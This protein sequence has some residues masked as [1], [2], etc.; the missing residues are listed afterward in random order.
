MKRLDYLKGYSAYLAKILRELDYSGV[1]KVVECLLQGRL[2]GST[3]FFIGN[4]GSAATASHF[5]QD[6]GETG[7][8][9][10]ARSFRSISLC[11]SM[12][13]VTALS[14]DYG[15]DSAF[16]SQLSSLF[17]KQDIL[18]A[19]SASG[20]S[21]NIVKAV[22][23][24]N[25]LKGITIGLVGFDGGKLLRMC[26]YALHV[27]TEEGEYGPVEDAH[28]ALEHMITTCIMIEDRHAKAKITPKPIGTPT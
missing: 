9:T 13:F 10:G 20:N 14:N 12:P 28:L 1:A 16:A 7:R 17:K 18:V 26:K 3:V 15:F 19:I 8:K 25:L 11:E 6:L 23:L 21:P 24:A 22:Q 4:G 5:A 27:K 2:R